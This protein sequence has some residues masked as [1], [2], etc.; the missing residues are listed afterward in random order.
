[1]AFRRPTLPV[2]PSRPFDGRLATGLFAVALLLPLVWGSVVLAAEPPPAQPPPPGGEKPEIPKPKDVS[3]QTTD[4]VALAATYFPG[5]KEKESVPVVLLHE[6]RGR[7]QR[8]GAANT[9]FS[10]V[11]Y[12]GL[13]KH[14]QARGNAVL[15]AD[16]RGHGDSNVRKIP[17]RADEV[18]DPE[19]MGG[20]DY[21]RM[22]TM[23]MPAIKNYLIARNNEGELNIEKLVVVGAEESALLAMYWTQ[24]DWSIPASGNQKQG[25]DIKAVI[26][27]SPTWSVPG[28]Q[29]SQI[30]RYQPLAMIPFDPQLQRVF[31]DGVK[32]DPRQGAVVFD[33]RREVPVRIL[34]GWHDPKNPADKP[35][36]HVREAM[37]DARKVYGLLKK[38]PE[39]DVLLGKFD[40]KAQGTALLQVPGLR[41]E[42]IIGNLVGKTV[43]SRQLSW[44]K[45]VDPYRGDADR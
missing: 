8:G 5:L 42:Q 44:Q 19:T 7:H 27:L 13:A 9:R 10:R 11:D 28:L 20:T 30:S 38:G 25:Q 24:L 33:F 12:A 41:A 36:L 16:L 18:I 31:R 23:D 40:T 1:M 45:R 4:G 21:Q 39:T 37:V 14:L 15:V 29:W 3:I 6:L 35:P 17:G 26:L 2:F 32:R 43:G 22:V 34:V